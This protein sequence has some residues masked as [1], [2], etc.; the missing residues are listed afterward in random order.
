M[1]MSISTTGKSGAA[2]LSLPSSSQPEADG[3]QSTANR[4]RT[5]LLRRRHG[6]KDSLG[7]NLSDLIFGEIQ[8]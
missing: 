3:W 1:T 2:A 6:L 7:A 5:A 8:S 4:I